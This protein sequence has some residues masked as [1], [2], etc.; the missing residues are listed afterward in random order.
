MDTRHPTVTEVATAFKLLKNNEGS[1][2]Y[3]LQP[4]LFKYG[5][6]HLVGAPE[7]LLK[8]VSDKKRDHSSEI[9]LWRSTFPKKVMK[10]CGNSL[11][12]SLLPISL[13]IC[14]HIVL[15]GIADDYNKIAWEIQVGFKATKGSRHQTF[16]LKQKLGQQNEFSRNI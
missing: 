1:I 12:I 9:L 5:G 2:I 7:K 14:E 3:N 11:G 16:L 6:D 15:H 10:K 8:R 13:K 4:D